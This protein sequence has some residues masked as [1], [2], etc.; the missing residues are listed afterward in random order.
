L[1]ELA[2]VTGYGGLRLGDEDLGISYSGTEIAEVA[3]ST[4]VRLSEAIDLGVRGLY[5]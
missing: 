2:A 3:L 1:F 5:A 4:I